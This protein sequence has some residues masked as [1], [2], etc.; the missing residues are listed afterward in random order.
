MK[1]ARV[2]VNFH[3]VGLEFSGLFGYHDGVEELQ[4]QAVYI[5][6]IEATD[7]W[8]IAISDEKRG[9]IYDKAVAAAHKQ[10][11]EGR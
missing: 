6:G 1:A 3:G 2:C 9:I 11:Y 5:N 8:D 7:F 10:V 4:I